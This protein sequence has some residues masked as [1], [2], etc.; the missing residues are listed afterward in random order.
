MWLRGQ[1]LTRQSKE[2]CAQ[3]NNVMLA[4]AAI[5]SE[6]VSHEQF[7]DRVFYTPK[8]CVLKPNDYNTEFGVDDFV[9][10]MVRQVATGSG[11]AR[12]RGLLPLKEFVGILTEIFNMASKQRYDAPV[13][14]EEYD[15]VVKW[16]AYNY[17]RTT[18]QR[19]G[20]SENLKH[21]GEFGEVA[22]Q[23]Y[24]YC[25]DNTSRSVA[26]DF[27]YTYLIS[28]LHASS[29]AVM[30]AAE[31]KA[32]ETLARSAEHKRTHGIEQSRLNYDL[33]PTTSAYSP[34]F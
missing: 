11:S 14:G 10:R 26:G 9:K 1:M 21:N 17:E 29:L 27:G 25:C 19:Y 8:S 20:M 13:T 18:Q 22:M 28:L 31:R 2:L 23:L 7:G 16:A 34:Q 15:E 5:N 12:D 33:T 4:V 24:K 30:V 32:A 6:I 3:T